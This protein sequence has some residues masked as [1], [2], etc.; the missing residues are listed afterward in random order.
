MTVA[1]GELKL[2]GGGGEPV[3]WR[4]TLS[5]HG[6]AT[7]PPNRVDTTA[8]TLKTTLTLASVG[9]LSASLRQPRPEVAELTVEA[10]VDPHHGGQLLATCRHMLRLDDDLSQFYERAAGDPALSWATGGAAGCC[11]ARPFSKT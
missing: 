5:S 7:L 8:W 10:N 4:R 9:A 2:R 6:V 11:G 1:L 3:D